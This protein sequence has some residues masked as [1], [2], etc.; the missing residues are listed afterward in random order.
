VVCSREIEST[1]FVQQPCSNLSESSE[2][3]GKVLTQKYALL[4][5]FCKHQKA[6]AKYCAAFAR[7]RSGVRLPSAPLYFYGDLQVKQELTMV[8]L[9]DPK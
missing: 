4:Q 5:A 7:R 1:P 2:I 6:R 3:L 9:D 8:T